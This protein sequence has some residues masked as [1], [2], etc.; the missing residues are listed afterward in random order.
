[1]AGGVGIAGAVNVGSTIATTGN[2]T[3]NG[4]KVG[5]GTAAAPNSN[6]VIGNGA[7]N[8]L[9][10]GAVSNVI[11]GNA[12]ADSLATGDFNVCI[13]VNALGATNATAV[14]ESVAIGRNAMILSEVAG[15]A[16]GG[17]ALASLVSGTNNTAI[18]AQALN[19]CTGSQNLALGDLALIFH[20]S[21]ANNVG[22]GVLAARNLGA[23]AAASSGSNIFCGTSAGRYFGAGSS[24]STD[25]LTRANNCIYFGASTRASAN[26]V[27]NEI[28]IGTAQTGDGSN[29]TVLGTSATTATRLAGTATSALRVDG[30]TVRIV[31]DRTPANAGAAGNEGDM[32]WDA[33]Y[34]YVCVAASTWKRAAISTW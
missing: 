20:T 13:G 2:A 3:I 26:D 8:A 12:A 5:S 25:G 27:T 32:C 29:T 24:D 33:N 22:I 1:V 7:G 23:S 15:V 14:S 11:I 9:E 28:V 6:V 18:G 10:A 4:I 17:R 31:N 21:G 30:D 19:A 16:V 34:I